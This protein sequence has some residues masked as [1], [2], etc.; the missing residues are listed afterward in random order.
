MISTNLK[1]NIIHNLSQNNYTY[2]QSCHSDILEG[3][4]YSGARATKKWAFSV[5]LC[6]HCEIG[7]ANSSGALIAVDSHL[8]II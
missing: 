7:T 3:F 2:P 6:H 5:E 1:K 4:S 8:K